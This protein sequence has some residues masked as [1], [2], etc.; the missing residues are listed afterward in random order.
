MTAKNGVEQSASAS[1]PSQPQGELRGTVDVVERDRISGWVQDI[2]CPETPVALRIV[3]D[4]KPIARILAN[5]FRQDL[6]DFGL[7][8]GR[9]A[10]ELLLP[11]PL[12]PLKAHNISIIRDSNGREL[13]GSPRIIPASTGLD[14]DM[15]RFLASALAGLSP[16][17]EADRALAFLVAETENLIAQRAEA[18]SDRRARETYKAFQ[19]RWGNRTP[20]DLPAGANR[21]VA[22]SQ[23]V[24]VIDDDIPVANRD[25][26]SQAILSH[27]LALRSL[28]YDVSFVA[29]QRM[30]LTGP[31]VKH[32]EDEGITVF[33]RPFYATVEDVLHRQADCFDVVYL[34]RISN[35][36]A[37]LPLVRLH[38]RR[39]RVLYS[40]ADLHHVRIFRQAHIE[41]EPNLMGHAQFL[42][43]AEIAASWMAD[44]TITHSHD[45]AAILRRESPTARVHVIGWG[46]PARSVTVPFAKRS[47]LAFI[48]CYD[49]APNVDAARF[50]VDEVM[51][52]VWAANPAIECLLVGSAMP[53]AVFHLASDKILKLGHVPDLAAV[54]ERVRLTVAPLRYGAGIKGKVLASLAAGV[55]CVMSSIAAEGLRLPALLDATVGASAA[56]LAERILRYHENETAN[57]QV[58]K[59]GERLIRD[60][61]NLLQVAVSLKAAIDGRH[62]VLVTAPAI[63]ARSTPDRP[64]QAQSGAATSSQPA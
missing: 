43:Q 13:D 53:E 28:F 6:S 17:P 45:E 58:A 15:E 22:P 21:P 59:A 3:A 27:M 49:H 52:L 29:S 19:R 11:Q 44:A 34:H 24:L 42:R 63:P 40:V 5:K 26:G 37:Y 16:G 2:T 30:D 31:I 64:G 10:Y 50:L 51:P 56:E 62:P 47:G 18:D 61:F 33:N 23:R 7:G 25:A 39:A 41:D 12:S 8:S 9:H 38:Q 14:P 36:H 55:P 32:L 48:G 57:R 35:A 54:F 20:T 1:P 46:V 60:Q 4:G